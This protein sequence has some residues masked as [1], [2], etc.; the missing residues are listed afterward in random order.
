MRQEYGV[1]ISV[2]SYSIGRLNDLE[3]GA[4]IVLG[5]GSIYRPTVADVR[6]SRGRRKG[7]GMSEDLDQT[8]FMGHSGDVRCMLYRM[9]RLKDDL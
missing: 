9:Y 5:M 8:I 4:T 2:T 3:G 7:R 6:L 1:I